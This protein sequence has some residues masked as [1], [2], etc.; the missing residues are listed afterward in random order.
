MSHLLAWGDAMWS[1]RSRAWLIGSFRRRAPRHA[2]CG[3]PEAIARYALCAI[4]EHTD[5]THASALGLVDEL[6]AMGGTSRQARRARRRTP[7]AA[8]PIGCPGNRTPA[9][10][11]DEASPRPERLALG[12]RIRP[13]WIT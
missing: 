2:A 4:G 9:G 7:G 13:V 11:S 5:E 12:I 8:Q 1:S 10:H 3:N 6:I